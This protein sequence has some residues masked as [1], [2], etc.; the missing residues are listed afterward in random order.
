MTPDWFDFKI[1]LG[2]VLTILA[3]IGSVFVRFEKLSRHVEGL[4]QQ[5]DLLTKHVAD[6]ASEVK[7]LLHRDA[8]I[9]ERMAAVEARQ[10]R[11][12]S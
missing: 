12:T 10:E 3:L 4:T 5:L 9:R 2:H 1:D 7:E 8:A 6:L 11:R